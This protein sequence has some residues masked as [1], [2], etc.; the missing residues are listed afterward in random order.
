MT[1][2][3]NNHLAKQ[4]VNHLYDGNQPDIKGH[5][6]N[7]AKGI[8]LTGSFIPS[9]QARQYSS[10]LHFSQTTPVIVR[11]SNS[12][13]IPNIEDQNPRASPRGIAIRFLLPEQQH[14]D[15]VGHSVEAFP[16]DTPEEFGRFLEIANQA[17]I[18]PKLFNQYIAEHPAT[19]R[20]FS[21]L[22][23]TPQSYA[24]TP[25]Y[26]LH[27]FKFINDQHKVTI[28]R[29]QIQPLLSIHNLSTVEAKQK[30]KNFLQQELVQHL[31]TKP[32]Q[33][34]LILQIANSEDNLMHISQPWDGK[35]Q[36]IELG[37]L[38]LTTILNN[39]SI[40]D[41]ALLFDPTHLTAGIDSVN[42]PMFVVRSPA[43]QLSAIRRRGEA[44]QH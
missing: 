12:T 42:D 41:Q 20:F 9:K 5:R 34:K 8:L 2:L 36:M 25:F 35:H 24:T 32:V 23:T 7:H 13:G 11:L 6:V 3:G 16:A 44:N 31:K 4:L 43:Y 27:T 30:D 33:Y 38:N 26:P 22:G 14:T 10:A 29:Y 17:N 21:L 28:G 39:Q 18:N 1:T 40:T 15:L 19:Q 37:T